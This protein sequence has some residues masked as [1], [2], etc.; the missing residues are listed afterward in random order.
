M[1]VTAEGLGAVTGRGESVGGE[2]DLANGRE[3]GGERMGCTSLPATVRGAVTSSEVRGFAT[4][5]SA[6]VWRCSSAVDWRVADP[7][8]CW[9][10]GEATTIGA[11][12]QRGSTV[13]LVVT[14]S[15]RFLL[16][17]VA[18]DAASKW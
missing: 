14:S 3:G 16:Q 2:G 9:T 11:A 13:E 6:T 10:R 15:S 18:V 17:A 1:Y 8:R 12:S 4:V 7:P 5:S